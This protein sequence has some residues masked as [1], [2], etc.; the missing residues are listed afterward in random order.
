MSSNLAVKLRSG[1]QKAHTAAENVGFMKCFLKGVVDRESFAKFLS[2]LY[3][4]YSELESAIKSH[5]NNP[6]IAAIDFPELNRQAALEKDMV[7][8]YGS[9]WRSLIAPSTSAQAYIKHIQELSVTE[10]ALLIGHTYTRYMGDLSGGQMLQKIAQSTLK[11]SGYEGT[12]FY[13]FEQIPDKKAFKDKYRQALDSVPVDDTTADRIVIEANSA[14]QFNMQM[15]TDLEG[16]LIK[17]LGQVVF[18]SLTST[19]NPG[20]TEAAAS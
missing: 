6:A 18:N 15:A 3:F 9:E 8:Y 1:T 16:N 19:R 11:L 4:V 10:P 5:A 13:N 7:F 14:F 17:A 2:N 20:S 12:S